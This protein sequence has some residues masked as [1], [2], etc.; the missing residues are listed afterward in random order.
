MKDIN[1]KL[2]D[3]SHVAEDKNSLRQ[4][5]LMFT[6]LIGHKLTIPGSGRW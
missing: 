5:T 4:T 1:K 6:R 3:G 2:F